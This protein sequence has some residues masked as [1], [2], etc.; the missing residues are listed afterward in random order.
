MGVGVSVGDSGA[1][2]S[3][4]GVPEINSCC[5]KSP[6]KNNWA[7]GENKTAQSAQTYYFSKG[8]PNKNIINFN[9]RLNLHYH[10]HQ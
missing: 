8:S 2:I 6:T 10:L 3:C 1:S 7:N 5:A 4:K 9:K